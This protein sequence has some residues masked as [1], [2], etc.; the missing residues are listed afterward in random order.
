MKHGCLVSPA[1]RDPSQI[2]VAASPKFRHLDLLSA[3]DALTK[4]GFGA[5]EVSCRQGHQTI[6]FPARPLREEN[7]ELGLP[8]EVV[9][10][11][12]ADHH[13]IGVT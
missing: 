1:L 11:V 10:A 9:E 13:G 8:V 4:G 5:L 7:L 12:S 2:L 3:L 6:T